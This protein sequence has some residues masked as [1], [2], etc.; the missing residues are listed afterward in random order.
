MWLS[1]AFFAASSGAT[2][3]RKQQ[4]TRRSGGRQLLLLPPPAV[5]IDWNASRAER[6]E[7]DRVGAGPHPA[8]TASS[9]PCNDIAAPAGPCRRR[10]MRA[11]TLNGRPC[12]STATPRA[13]TGNI[14]GRTAMASPPSVCTIRTVDTAKPILYAHASQD[15]HRTRRAY[16]VYY[17]PLLKPI[18]AAVR[19]AFA[20]FFYT[21]TVYC[22]TK[23]ERS[24]N[25]KITDQRIG[26]ILKLRELR[27]G[28]CMGNVALQKIT[29]GSHCFKHLYCRGQSMY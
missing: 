19:A 6:R 27:D 26:A 24:K 15:A 23:P 29:S 13:P 8:L 7:A 4:A 21:L 10:I 22:N 17:I 28:Q 9:Q 20:D 16:A 12:S 2:R 14:P 11:M 5:W 1:I 18:S 25:Q 3:N